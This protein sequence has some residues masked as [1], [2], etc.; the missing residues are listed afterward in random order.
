MIELIKSAQPY[1]FAIVFL[2]IYVAENIFPQRKDLIDTKHDLRNGLIGPINLAVVFVFG[3][4]LQKVIAWAGTKNFGL[5]YFLGLNEIVSIIFQ[6][7]CIDIIMYWWHRFNHIIPFFWQFHKFHHVDTKLN[8]TTALRFH[9]V[10]LMLSFLYRLFFFLVLGIGL[11]A[12]I[13]YGILYLPVIIFHHSNLRISE[14]TD[15]FLRTIIVTPGMHRIHHSVLPFKKRS[16]YSSL[17]PWWDKVFKTN[18]QKPVQEIRFGIDE[19]I[20]KL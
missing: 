20:Y 19:S 8:A 7:L 1:S 14:K 17:L 5:F 4:Y 11:P 18:R 16:N 13:I 2:L 9:A 12:I 6:F 3:F 15:N 10:E